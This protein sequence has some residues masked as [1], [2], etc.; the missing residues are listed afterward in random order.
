MNLSDIV[1]A[2]QSAGRSVGSIPGTTPAPTGNATGGSY[3]VVSGG[4]GMTLGSV[5]AIYLI[6]RVSGLLPR[7]ARII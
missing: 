6:L 5:A 2:A 7:W 4:T 1:S 3:G